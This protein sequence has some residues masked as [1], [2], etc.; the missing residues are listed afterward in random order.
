MKVSLS[1]RQ[2]SFPRRCAC[3]DCYPTTSL[4]VSGTEANR[5]SRT[6][7]WTWEIPVCT[8]CKGHVTAFDRLLLACFMVTAGLAGLS[9]LSS[10]LD[11]SPPI[12]LVA[13][14]VLGATTS[15]ALWRKRIGNTGSPACAGIG[16][17]MTYG[18]SVGSVHTFDIKSKAYA[19]AFIRE[20]QQK[21]VN[22][23]VAVA[24]ILQSAEDGLRKAPRRSFR[25][26]V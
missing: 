23:N 4:S 22:A 19:K 20:N 25:S 11:L 6:K 9:L 2:F 21:I 17:P 26:R 14:L 5:R 10:I 7:G 3:C 15:L 24:R 1:G 18:G 12:A 8:R 16:R 13:I